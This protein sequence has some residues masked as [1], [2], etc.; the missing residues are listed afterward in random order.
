M[1]SVRCVCVANACMNSFPIT[2]VNSFV[3][4]QER[5]MVFNKAP[6]SCS[7]L[8][9]TTT[10]GFCVCVCVCVCVCAWM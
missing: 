4:R 5:G 7:F 10:D 1:A 3:Y 9:P 2:A 6:S 8:A